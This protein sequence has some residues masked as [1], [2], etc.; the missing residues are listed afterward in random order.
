MERSRCR[1][2]STRGS[3]CSRSTARALAEL[4]EP[5][6]A[7]AESGF[8]VAEKTAEDWAPRS[9]SWRAAGGRKTYLVDGKAPG[10]GAIFVQKNLARS[11]GRCEGRP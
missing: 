1:A 3:A 4:L 11:C 10:A 5:A 9:R 2:R 8:P 6:I 7:L